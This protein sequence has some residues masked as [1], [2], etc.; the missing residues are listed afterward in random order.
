[1]LCRLHYRTIY[2]SISWQMDINHRTPGN[3]VRL[4]NL[5]IDLDSKRSDYI[6]QKS[7]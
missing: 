3:T 6:D 7:K 1:M 5:Y 2:L 4:E